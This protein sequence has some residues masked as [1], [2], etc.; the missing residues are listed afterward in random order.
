MSRK[1]RDTNLLSEAV[2]RWS[3]SKVGALLRSACRRQD[4]LGVVVAPKLAADHAL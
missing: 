2:E 4:M 1:G 3:V